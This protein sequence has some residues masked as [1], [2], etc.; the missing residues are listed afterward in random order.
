MIQTIPKVQ[1]TDRT[2]NQLQD[3]IGGAIGGILKLP[4]NNSVHLKNVS[5]AIGSNTINHTLGRELI[6]WLIV[7][8][9]AGANIYDTQDTNAL[10]DKTLVLVSDATATVDLIVF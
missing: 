6:G 3:Y 2:I 1:T 7:R 4:L 10:P 8:Q 9:R 5:L